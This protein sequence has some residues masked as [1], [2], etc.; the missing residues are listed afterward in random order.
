MNEWMNKWMNE[1]KV[2]SL[3]LEE[4]IINE[5]SGVYNAQI[6][7]I[8]CM[9]WIAHYFFGIVVLSILPCKI[10]KFNRMY[11]FLTEDCKGNSYVKWLIIKWVND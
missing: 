11:T 3:E 4:T 2:Y 7:F 9:R 6:Q 8:L 1:W 10:K 5:N